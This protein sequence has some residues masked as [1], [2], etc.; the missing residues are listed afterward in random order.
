MGSD[1]PY[2]PKE[3]EALRETW[4]TIAGG[5][6]NRLLATL[7]A[8][9]TKRDEVM[10]VLDSTVR[11]CAERGREIEAERDEARAEVGQLRDEVRRLIDGLAA[12]PD[13]A[14][15]EVGRMFNVVTRATSGLNLS[16]RAKL[17]QLIVDMDRAGVATRGDMEGGDGG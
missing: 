13:L 2:T 10:R 6:V 1:K 15:D 12:E 11:K 8:V 14:D 9:T 4:Q 16:T 5:S 17:A 3:L 7:D